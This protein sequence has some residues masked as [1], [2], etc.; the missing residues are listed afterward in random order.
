[1]KREGTTQTRSQQSKTW[2]YSSEQYLAVRNATCPLN[3]LLSTLLVCICMCICLFSWMNSVGYNVCAL[4]YLWS[5]LYWD[6]AL[7]ATAQLLRYC[8]QWS[9]L[10]VKR[11]ELAPNVNGMQDSIRFPFHPPGALIC[12]T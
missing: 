6:T 12:Y 4:R 9:A 10:H 2:T 8:T 5:S 1:M 11:I 3:K 7:W